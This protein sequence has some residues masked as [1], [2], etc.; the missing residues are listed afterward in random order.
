MTKLVERMKEL[1]S[2]DPETGL[3]RWKVTRGGPRKAGD[4]AGTS[5]SYIHL[6]FDGKTYYAHRLAWLYMTGEW[7]KGEIDHIDG[8]KKNNRFANLRDV[9]RSVNVQNVRRRGVHFAKKLGRWT[10]QIVSNGRNVHL[11]S[12]ATEDEARQAYLAGK[13]VLH[14]GCPLNDRP[15]SIEDVSYLPSGINR[16]NTSGF[17]GVSFKRARGTYEAHIC[18]A[19]KYKFVG[20][21]RTAQEAAEARAKALQQRQAA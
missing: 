10:A 16:R 1:L 5:A 20:H 11:G 19:G 6:T 18:V 13:R 2:Y 14:Q 17:T 21:F 3:F 12:Y 7:P 9:S 15:P 4:I 8:D